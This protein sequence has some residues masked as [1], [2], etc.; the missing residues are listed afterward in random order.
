MNKYKRLE[1]EEAYR[2]ANFANLKLNKYSDPDGF[3]D[4]AYQLDDDYA[5][6]I[7]LMHPQ[8]LWIDVPD[9]GIN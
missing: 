1:G 5:E 3:E 9:K 2:F 8:L 6:E 7:Y 4:E